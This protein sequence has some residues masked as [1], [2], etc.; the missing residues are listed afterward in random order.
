MTTTTATTIW[1]A[2]EDQLDPQVRAAFPGVEFQTY[3]RIEQL[4]SECKDVALMTPT[5]AYALLSGAHCPE[6]RVVLWL[7]SGQTVEESLLTQVL[8]QLT[9]S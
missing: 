2:R 6:M 8:S 3:G 4:V 7:E 5:D 1:I 9:F